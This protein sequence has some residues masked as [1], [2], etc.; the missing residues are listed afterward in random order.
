MKVLV[1]GKGG[2]GK[3]TLVVLLARALAKRGFKVLVVD[4]D[5]SNVTLYRMLGVEPPPRT[6]TEYLGG[7]RFVADA[8]FRGKHGID[9][10]FARRGVTGLPPDCAVWQNSLGL[11]VI[12][13]VTG[14]GEG[15]ACPLNALAREFLNRVRL[16]SDEVI[17]VDTDAG[18]EHFG[19]G[20]EEAC[21]LLLMVV[22]PTYESLVMAERAE[23]FARKAGKPLYYVLNKV[24]ERSE[25]ILL[26]RIPREK[27]L[28]TLRYRSEWVEKSLKGEPLGEP[29]S[30]VEELASLIISGLRSK[31]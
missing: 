28:A 12:G 24:D 13:K 4:S 6:L 7:R 17:L 26:E 11:L 21:D 15:C 23:G 25:R 22:D 2:A 31:R 10:S 20:V 3:S 9:W 19:R 16:A 14:F 27:V 29:P 30:E 18:I 5:E 8:L 1:F